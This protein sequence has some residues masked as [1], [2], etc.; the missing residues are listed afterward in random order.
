MRNE[1]NLDVY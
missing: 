1:P